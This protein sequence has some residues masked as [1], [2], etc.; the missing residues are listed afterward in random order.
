MAAKSLCSVVECGKPSMAKGWCNKHY[1][2]LRGGPRCAA[3]D[4]QRPAQTKGYCEPHSKRFKRHGDPL[5]GSRRAAPGAPAEWIKANTAHL[6]DECVAWPFSRADNGY[7]A[8][9]DAGAYISAHRHMCR[10][11]HGEPPSPRHVAAHSCG[12]GHL[13]C[14]NPRH[15]RWATPSQ[16]TLDSIAHGTHPAAYSAGSAHP[17][18]KLTEAMVLEIRAKLAGGN[19]PADLAREY[20]VCASAI[21]QIKARR[22][23]V[24]I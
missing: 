11:A 22:A 7:G 21:S 17:N 4:C 16:N 2:L 24:H 20:G 10:A 5:G 18:A 9:W 3:A 13:G 23:W 15:L 14:V 6:G 1:Y 19:G 8:S 12:N